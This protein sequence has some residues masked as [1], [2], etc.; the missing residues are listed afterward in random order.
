MDGTEGDGVKSVKGV[1]AGACEN[2]CARHGKTAGSSTVT[3]F[4]A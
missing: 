3:T 1:K 2:A 4:V